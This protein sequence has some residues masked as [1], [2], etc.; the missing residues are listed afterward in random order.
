[1][2][3]IVEN[4]AT[5]HRRPARSNVVS[6]NRAVVECQRRAAGKLPIVRDA[7]AARSVVNGIGGNDAVIQSQVRMVVVDTGAAKAEICRSIGERQPLNRC[8]MAGGDVENAKLWC[9]SRTR[10]S[11]EVR[12]RTHHDDTLIDHKLGGGQ[13]YGLAFERGI[14]INRVAIAGRTDRTAQ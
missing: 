11:E 10:D 14:E 13:R 2:D 7:A 4:A 9:V 8:R 3:S 12:T 6:T 5:E 1:M